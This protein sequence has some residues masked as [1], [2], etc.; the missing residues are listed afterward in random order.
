[1]TAQTSSVSIVILN[2]NSKD[3]LADCLASVAALDYPAGNLEVLVVDNGSTDGSPVWVRA[4]Y[5]SVHVVELGENLGFAEGNNRGVAAAR[6]EII[7]FLNTDTR[8]EPNWLSELVGPLSGTPGTGADPALA[9]TASRM[10]DW[11]GRGVDF[12]VYAT[13]LGMPH[14]HREERKFRRPADYGSPHYLLF[15]SGGAM[16][17]RRDAFFD[18]GGFDADYFMYHEDVDLGWRLWLCGYKVL[19]VP[20]AVVYHKS[21]GSWTGDQAPHYFLNE[22]NALFTVIKNTGDAWLARLL[23]LLLLWQFERV[24]LYLGVEPSAYTAGSDPATPAS[25]TVARGALSGVAAVRDLIRHLPRLAE[26][27]AAIQA[28]RVRSDEEIAALLELPRDTFVQMM[29]G[30]N[31]DFSGA[32]GLLD[33]LGL[34][35]GE[36]SLFGRAMARLGEAAGPGDP[37][38]RRLLDC[39]FFLAD[40][41]PEETE[42]VFGGEMLARLSEHVGV[43]PPDL[44]L[45]ARMLVLVGSKQLAGLTL[46]HPS[47]PRARRNTAD[48]TKDLLSLMREAVWRDAV[49]YREELHK[50]TDQLLKTLEAHRDWMAGFAAREAE[51][52]AERA[53]VEA[54]LT[55]MRRAREDLE[56][57]LD[58]QRRENSRLQVELGRVEADLTAMRRAREDLEAGLDDQRRENSRLQVELEKQEALLVAREAALQ[59]ISG[60]LQAIQSSLGYRL[61]TGYHRLA[62]R[63]FP[64]GSRRGSLH[65]RL[66]RSIRWLL[67][68]RL[69]ILGRRP[70]PT[71]PAETS[72]DA[73]A[74]GA[75][76]VEIRPLAFPEVVKPTASI[77]IPVH[78]QAAHT[79]NCLKT[80][81]DH[82]SDVSYEVIVMDDASPDDTPAMLQQ[83][84]NIKVVRNAQ[85]QGFVDACRRGAAVAAG[86]ALLFLNNDTRVRPGWLQALVRT[87]D[88]DPTVG[89]L[90]A[91]L[92]YPD[93]R[94]QEAGAIIWQDGFGWNYGR[95]DD[96]GKPEYNFVRE[97]D[98]CSGACLMVRREVWDRVGGFDRRYAPAYYEDADL[99]FAARSLGY[100]VLYQPRAE[101]IHF[102]GM[103][104][105]TD[106]AQGVKRYQEVNREKF[107]LKWRGVLDLEHRPHG[108]DL[109]L[110]RQRG[111]GKLAL[112]VDHHVPMPDRDSGSL[113]MSH[114][115]HLL[116]GFGY[117]VTFL[118]DNLA[119]MEPYTGDL[120]QQGIE[121]LYAPAQTE[122]FLARLG[123]HLDLVWMARPYVASR[124]LPPLRR[125]APRARFVY[126]TVDLHFLRESRR[127]AIEQSQAVKRKADEYREQE[128]SLAR[129]CD[130]TVVV[131]E[132]E[133]EVLL[134]LEPNLRAYVIPNVHP[135]M[136]RTRSFSE[137]R[138]LLFVGN[139]IHPPNEDGMIHFVREIWPLVK[140]ALPDV[141]LYVV[142]DSPTSA[143]TSLAGWDIVVTGWV[144]DVAPYF[145]NC[146]VLVAPLRY[147]AGVK[148]KIG[149]SLSFGLPVV[150]TS[151]GAEGL[152]LVDGRDVLIADTAQAFAQKV[153]RLYVEG[154]LWKTLSENSRALV[155]E[156]YTPEVVGRRLHAMLSELIGAPRARQVE[157]AG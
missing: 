65:R 99:A 90:G 98:Y 106:V 38:S 126:D 45:L 104:H 124:W 144:Q 32:V 62:D 27:R 12:P 125:W 19:Y 148:G 57:G 138:D 145:Q 154:V 33:M 55:A 50:R 13:L 70:G 44:S 156:R 80:I 93:G 136:E 56:A 142:G 14:A 25:W 102:E 149:Q 79:Y 37:D 110:A 151:I 134:A 88:A 83:I 127:A 46:D 116:A 117:A 8:V 100:K 91:K 113:R 130:A 96:P 73:L 22:R 5:P 78:G 118:P 141:R 85:A 74:S 51:W 112:V 133:R 58:D 119:R 15:P 94:L 52:S 132:A 3:H 82:T 7:A 137:R 24:G 54:D 72:P 9:A 89:I 39:L 143:V 109:L 150:T 71:A 95:L 1:M 61:L 87:M 146:R 20:S 157:H 29:L 120:Q 152:N 26:K 75:A 6:G 97:V 153:V 43:A 129:S 111:R 60:D 53:R 105:G 103:S 21:G 101:V 121:A 18:V 135:V 66:L 131:S 11:E 86:E 76:L 59:R 69:R 30:A 81:L 115:L 63:L 41:T 28:R 139:F 67:D 92:V 107:S 155:G 49:F 10:L 140:E 23:P 35:S 114:I 147:G 31:A 42:K 4:A 128:L 68:V 17:I 2:H 122:E 16:A 84:V 108:T 47:G 48:D 36:A 123:A 34:G 64:P 77:I 40:H